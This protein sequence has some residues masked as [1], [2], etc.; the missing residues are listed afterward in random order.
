M[1]YDSFISEKWFVRSKINLQAEALFMFNALLKGDA[2]NFYTEEVATYQ[3]RLDY[4]A[5]RLRVLFVAITRAR[6]ELIITWNTGRS[7]ADNRNL[8]LPYPWLPC[9]LSGRKTSMPLPPDFH[10]S[11][12]SLQ[13]YLDCPRRFELRYLQKVKWRLPSASPSWNRN[14]T[15]CSGNNFTTCCTR[16]SSASRRNC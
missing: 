5:E 3:A 2:I 13:D 4:A 6:K 15:F 12:S 14:A 16:S 1:P 8:S 11:Q 7:A 10:F 9:K